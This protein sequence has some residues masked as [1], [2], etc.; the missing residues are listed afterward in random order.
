MV[1]GRARYQRMKNWAWQ[2]YLRESL[3]RTSRRRDLDGTE[4]P[5][6]AAVDCNKPSRPQN[7]SSEQPSHC[8][9]TAREPIDHKSSG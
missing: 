2:L 7:R 1:F 8:P 5:E 4:L 3:R 6:Q 9:A